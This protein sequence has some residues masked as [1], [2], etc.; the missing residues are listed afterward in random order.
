M[1]PVDLVIAKSLYE[2]DEF[3]SREILQQ[4]VIWRFYEAGYERSF[5]GA[6]GVVDLGD[7]D[8]PEVS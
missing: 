3:L 1:S 7:L 4:R 2:D 8:A 6:P 5:H